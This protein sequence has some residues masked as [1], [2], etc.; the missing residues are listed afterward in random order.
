MTG[1]V[2]MN[3]N[4]IK[5]R[6]DPDDDKQPVTQGYGN[7]KYLKVDGTSSMTGNLNMENK[8]LTN[9]KDG[10]NP[11]DAVTRKQLDNVGI[12]NIT[13]DIDF[14]NSYIIQ[15]SKKRTFAQLKAKEK[16]LVSFDEV[17]ENFVGFNEAFAM[18]TYLDM[19]DN[20]IYNVKTPTSNDQAENKSYVD[21]KSTNTMNAAAMIQAT[22]AELAD[23][24]KKD[25]SVAM[26]G[27]LQTGNNRIYNRPLPNGSNQ[28]TTVAYNDLKYVKL[29]GTSSMG[30]DLN[31]N[32]KKV[33]HLRPPT[34]DTDAATKKYV[35]D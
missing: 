7:S 5:N 22:K 17:K 31:M 1:D 14:K 21:T 27:N 25:G 26:T 6:P 19:G 2:N 23:Y 3:N 9:V 10:T 15:N 11:S 16:S 4:K 29:D 32:N 30:G 8:K 34:S 33:I 35:N 28:P 13:A 18:K 12:G 20:Y 24:L